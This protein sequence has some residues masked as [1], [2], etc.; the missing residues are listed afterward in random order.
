MIYN[1]I[2]AVTP[3]IL[4]GLLIEKSIIMLRM[5]LHNGVVLKPSITRCDKSI[6]NKFEYDFVMVVINQMLSSLG[7]SPQKYCNC[8]LEKV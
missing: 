4:I 6:H 5:V 8:T 3:F 1:T 2:P 7:K